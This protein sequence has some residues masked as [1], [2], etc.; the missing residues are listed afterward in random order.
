MKRILVGL[1]GL[2]LS[3]SVSAVGDEPTMLRRQVE[4][5]ML[6]TGNILVDPQ[7]GIKEYA[8]DQPDMVPKE[9]LK[10]VNQNIEQWRFEPMTHEGKPVSVR[11]KMSVLLL[12]EKSESGGLRARI[13]GTTF[14]AS[15]DEAEV[16]AG[17]QIS[18]QEMEPPHFP[19]QAQQYG[20]QGTVYL[21]LRVDRDGKVEDV[22][23]EQVNLKVLA[24]ENGMVR[25]RR[26]LEKAAVEAA[27][28]WKFRPPSKGE[29]A[30]RPFWLV[31]VPVDYRFYGSQKYG[32][33]DAYVSGP[34]KNIPWQ[35]WSDPPG[36]SP[37]AMV[38]DGSVYRVD[39]KGSLR[40]LTPL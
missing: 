18:S 12:A 29:Q 6:L 40:L 17:T 21:A 39:G 27:R 19:T 32:E 36:Y 8:I 16:E 31:K 23:A 28:D 2:M 24:S 1:L 4:A 22:I 10:F 33:W 11:N 7:G 34:R 13:A 38:A 26:V 15:M 25:W 20:V 5:R 35:D 3:F 37:D 9:I 14:R 30:D